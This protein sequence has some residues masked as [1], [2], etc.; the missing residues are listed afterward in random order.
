MRAPDRGTRTSL[1]LSAVDGGWRLRGSWTQ[2]RSGRIK[3][4]LAVIRVCDI[5]MNGTELQFACLNDPRLAAHALSPSPAWL[6]SADASRMLWANPPAAAIFE[7]AFAGRRRNAA[8]SSQASGRR[9]DRASRRHVAAGRRAAAR[10]AARFRRQPRR[11]ADLPV[12]AHCRSPTTPPPSWWFR[13]NA[14]AR[15]FALP[16]RAHRLLHAISNCRRRSSPP[17]AN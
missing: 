16:E 14:P 2:R 9:A 10:T 5:A 17:M 4:S 12:L 13:P 8:A 3:V 6:W 11:R 15:S 1:R 7:A